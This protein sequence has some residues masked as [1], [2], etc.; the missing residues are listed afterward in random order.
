MCQAVVLVHRGGGDYRSIV[1]VEVVWKVVT[2][3]L[4]LRFTASTD[5]RGFFHG[6]RAGCGTGTASFEA[7]I[8]QQLTAMR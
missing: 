7:K 1:L 4:N 6:F 2:V 5:F 8:L 3:I